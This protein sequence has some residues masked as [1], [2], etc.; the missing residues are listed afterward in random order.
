MNL[1][2]IKSDFKN[3]VKKFPILLLIIKNIIFKYQMFLSRSKWKSLQK[4]SEIKL[5]L[6][7]GSKKGLDGWTTVD[8]GDAD[9]KWDLKFGIPLSDKSVD[10]IYSSHLLEHI[11]YNHLIPFLKEC[12]R[13]LKIGGEFSVCVPNFKLYI[14]AYKDG[15]LF[16][17][18]DKWWQP[19]MIN[20]GS[21][22]DQLNYITYMLDQHKY[23]FDEQNLI[24]TLIT[25]GFLNVSLREFDDSLDLI[26]RFEESI[27][28]KAI[29]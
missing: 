24:N 17:A 1:K 2:K 12:R 18:R 5:E 9:I 6:G 21:N 29:R 23:M 11:S 4:Q 3:L 20:T 26:S 19:A 27:Y 10:I 13:V 22:I 7:S 16:Q 15:K 25:A 28:A 8:I 14:D